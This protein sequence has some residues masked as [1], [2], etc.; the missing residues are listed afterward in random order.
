M[1]KPKY[2]H[3]SV[4]MGNAPPILQGFEHINR[5]WDTK[6]DIFAAKILPGE[7][8]VSQHGELITTVL[9]SCVS[10]CIR[11]RVTGL[12]G[13]NHFMLPDSREHKRSSAWENTPVSAETRYG[14]VA[15]ERLINAILAGGGRRQNL[16]IKLFGGGKVLSINTDIGGKNVDFVKHYLQTEGFEIEAEDTRGVWPRKIQY[17]PLT[18]RVRVKRLTALHNDTLERREKEYLDALK[19]KKVEGK[20]DLF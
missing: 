5:Y 17:F 8:Y 12:G 14:N 15:M 6:H 10:A 3:N 4:D 13:M 16:E 18:G 1:N 2:T 7:F 19:E 11:D 20:I 9:G